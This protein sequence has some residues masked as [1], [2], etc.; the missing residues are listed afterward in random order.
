VK[1]QLLFYCAIEIVLFVV[2]RVKCFTL[3]NASLLVIVSINVPPCFNFKLFAFKVVKVNFKAGNRFAVP[4][5]KTSTI[6]IR[7]IAAYIYMCD[8][9][10]INQVQIKF[11]TAICNGVFLC[12][13]IVV[14]HCLVSTDIV[15]Q[16]NANRKWY[17]RV[18]TCEYRLIK[19]FLNAFLGY[20]ALYALGLTNKTGLL[21]LKI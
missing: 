16:G 10:C 1:A 18:N 5:K 20:C 14:S 11:C 21:N 4:E 3:I 12:E 2:V 19:N 7:G 13:C 15:H 6:V 8:S 17:L 9:R